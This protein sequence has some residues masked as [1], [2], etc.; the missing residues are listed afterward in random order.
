MEWGLR[1]GTTGAFFQALRSNGVKPENYLSFD[2]ERA[3][4]LRMIDPGYPVSSLEEGWR[5]AVGYDPVDTRP[6][7]P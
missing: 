7:T 2:P 3:I 4:W 6:G 1:G 5:K